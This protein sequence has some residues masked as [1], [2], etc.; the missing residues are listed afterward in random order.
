MPSTAQCPHCQVACSVR[1]EDLGRAVRCPRCQQPFQANAPSSA[2]PPDGPAV[3]FA[4]PACRRSLAEPRSRAGEKI[5]CPGCGQKLQIPT[6]P[7][8]KTVLGVLEDPPI[9]TEIAESPLP[10]PPPPPEMLYQ[11][12]PLEPAY[13]HESA[14]AEPQ[15]CCPFCKA[16]MIPLRRSRVSQ[17]GWLTF[18]ILLMIVFCGWPFCWIPLLVMRD[19]FRQCA[20]CGME[21]G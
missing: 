1:D 8:N 17:A 16:D 20:Y 7:P 21:L 4:C 3:H 10:V 12:P 9:K 2:P 15:F 19:Q 13:T 14:R 18:F 6:P 5:L 11:V